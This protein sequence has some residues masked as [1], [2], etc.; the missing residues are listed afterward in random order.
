[1]SG[2]SRL[3]RATPAQL[4]AVLQA[5]QRSLWMPEFLS[6]LPIAGL[7]GTMRKRLK[8]SPA[9]LHARLKTGSLHAVVAI[10]GYV[11]DASGHPCVVVAFINDEHVANGAGRAALDALVDWVSRAPQP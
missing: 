5:G 10:A 3:E 4:A 6:S 1:G 11:P 2:L 8:D 9:A 7:D